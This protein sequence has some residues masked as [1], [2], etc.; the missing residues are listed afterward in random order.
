MWRLELKSKQ[1]SVGAGMMLFVNCRG[2]ARAKGLALMILDIK[3]LE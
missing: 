2:G 1:T 3:G